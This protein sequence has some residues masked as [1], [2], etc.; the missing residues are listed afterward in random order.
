MRNLLPALALAGAVSLFATAPMANAQSGGSSDSSSGSDSGSNAGMTMTMPGMGM[1]GMGMGMSGM[2]MPGMGMG[3]S[4]MGMP[5]MGMGM[6]GM[7][8]SGMG[9]PGMGMGMSS[10]SSTSS[11]S[12]SSST[13][14]SGSSS[15]T[16]AYG[17]VTPFV[18]PQSGV[19]Q[20]GRPFIYQAQGIYGPYDGFGYPVTIN[21]IG[22]SNG[23]TFQRS[24]H[25]YIPSPCPS[26]SSLSGVGS[27][28]SLGT[29]GSS[30][31]YPSMG[32]SSSGTW[33]G[34]WGSTPASAGAVFPS[35]GM[36]PALGSGLYR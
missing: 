20:N 31:G 14:A 5:G 16:C 7:G 24:S 21:T 19:D 11:T 26:S 27:L 32:A 2:G 9:M 13:S 22:V 36:L 34:W 12:S 33:G 18:V 10:T 17:Q 1:P 3:M 15:Y 29:L 28:G 8:M 25:G 35:P 30:F 23:S 4:G 6:S